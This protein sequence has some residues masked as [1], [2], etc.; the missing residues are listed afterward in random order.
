MG[1]GYPPAVYG[2]RP[3]FSGFE[4]IAPIVC[5]WLP[6]AYAGLSPRDLGSGGDPPSR[7]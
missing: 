1:F 2:G 4:F 5:P 7:A 3:D 6:E